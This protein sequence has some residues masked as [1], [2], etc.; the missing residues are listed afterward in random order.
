MNLFNIYYI[1]FPK[2]YEIKMMFSNIV[3][4]GKE[5]TTDKA[6]EGDVDIKAQMGAK[7]FN[8]FNVGGDIGGGVKGSDSKKVLE[9]FEVKTTKS[10]ILNDVVERCQS[11][12]SFEGVTEGQLIMID[13]VKLSLENEGELRTVKLFQSG[14]FKDMSV[15][16]ANGFDFTNLFNSMFK[17]YAYKIKGSLNNK[18]ESILIKI[19]LTF[20][21][22]FESS[23][24]VD[25]LFV[26]KVS[27]L[28]LYKGKI[29]IDELKNSFQFFQELGSLQ[30]TI[31]KTSSSEDDE[32]QDSQYP[33]DEVEAYKFT[34]SGDGKDYH[35][36][37][38]LAI[39]QKVNIPD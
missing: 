9:T 21:N 16:G 33:Q 7:F 38:L 4:K 11:I 23:Y 18:P 31:A 37:D 3:S 25:D 5:V 27:I 15:P 36:I 39:V 19:P 30:N 34:S 28:G 17:D 2:V 22:E 6:I 8:L 26:G 1:N 29:T 35:Y 24:S 20:E 32:I 10:V 14:A 13:N 12:S